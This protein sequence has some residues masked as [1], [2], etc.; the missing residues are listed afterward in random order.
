MVQSDKVCC[1]VDSRPLSCSYQFTVS[2]PSCITQSFFQLAAQAQQNNVQT[3]G[4]KKGSAPISYVQEH[5]K[6]PIISHLKDLGLKFFGI[7]TLIQNIRQQKIIVV[8]TPQLKDIQ[9]DGEGNALYQFEGYAPKEL[10]MQS[11]K[12]LPFK[13][14]PRKQYR[15]ID[16]QVTSFLQDEEAI[17]SRFKAESGINVGDWVCFKAWI[18]DKNDNPVFDQNTSQIWLKIGN[19]EPDVIFQGIFLGKKIGDRFITD[20]SSLQNYFCEASNSSY[21][22]VVEIK[23]IVPYGY[24]SFD[25]FKQY[26]K[27]KTHKDL[28]SKITEVFSF[29]NDI[30]Q[31]RSIGHEALG[32]IIKKNQIVLPDSAI[33]V[34]K[35]LILS[36]LQ[37]KPDFIVY[38]QDREFD[39]QV[40]SMAKRQLLDSVVAEYVGYQDNLTVSQ[41]DIKA[42]LQITQRSRLKDFLYFPFMKTQLSGQEFPVEGES[43]A[44]FCLR[45]KSV[46]HI[47][48]HLTKK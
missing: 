30:S 36:D 11:W 6:A 8:G 2:V 33:A 34:Q 22:Y 31:R 16:K 14:T 18:I 27:I 15:D 41:Q 26:F 28:L 24:F 12:Y 1:L 9:V 48:H 20:N 37:F 46:N 4:F 42:I 23:D 44:Q 38:K 3:T 40:T 32:L 39:A 43:L 25:L 45:E 47:I 21:T 5:F 35:R 19:E 7:N 29:N 13:P 10:Y 17:Q